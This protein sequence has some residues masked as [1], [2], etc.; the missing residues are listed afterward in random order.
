MIDREEA[1]LLA[2]NCMR[3][4]GFEVSFATPSG[5]FPVALETLLN[6]YDVDLVFDVGAGRGQYGAMLRSA[7]YDGRIVSFEPVP[8]S[9]SRLKARAG[10][11][12][13]WTVSPPVALG[14]E[15]GVA[16]L[17]IHTDPDQSSLLRTDAPTS[18]DSEGVVEVER[19]TL[20]QEWERYADD[21]SS[22]FVKL[23]VQG[24]EDRVVRGSGERL[25]RIVGWQ[26]EIPFAKRYRKQAGRKQLSSMMHKEDYVLTQIRP[27][28]V[29]DETGRMIEAD[30]VYFRNIN[31]YLG[32]FD[33]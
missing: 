19:T 26:L 30:A 7:G 2:K 14:E 33:G 3:R 11:D 16:R 32:C 8:S 23:D 9:H 10:A 17:N 29:D 1:K 25:S 21:A 5:S 20:D 22:V 4:L 12:R 24:Y 6:T 27:T 13:L 28:V 15:E 18:G 31:G